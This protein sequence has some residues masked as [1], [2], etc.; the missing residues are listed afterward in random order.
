MACRNG[1]SG[2]GGQSYH[3]CCGV[4][5]TNAPIDQ[6]ICYEDTLPYSAGIITGAT[7]CTSPGCIVYLSGCCSGDLYGMAGN[8]WL[9]GVAGTWYFSGV[10]AL[11]DGCYTIMD[12]TGST[13]IMTFLSTDI[14]KW[15]QIVTIHCANVIVIVSI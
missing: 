6:P 2:P 12:T 7:L 5:I 3:D 4:A 1:N 13:I 10:T 9:S 14:V 8:T 15:Y 11:P